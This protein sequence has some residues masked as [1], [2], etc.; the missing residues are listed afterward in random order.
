MVDRV[1]ATVN[2][3]LGFVTVALILAIVYAFTEDDTIPGGVVGGF[4][5]ASLTLVIGSAVVFNT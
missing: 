5:I 3:T 1:K 2:T 4:S